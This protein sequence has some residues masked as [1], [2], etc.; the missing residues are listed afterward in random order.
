MTVCA[1]GQSASPDAEQLNIVR[2]FLAWAQRADAGGRA[3]A[4]S[5]LARAY[6]YSDLDAALRHEAEMGLTLLLDDPCALVRRALAEALAGA[7][8]APH[9]VILALACDQSEVSAAVLARSPVLT[10]AE[11]VDCAAIGDGRAQAALAR[12]PRLGIGV[13]MALAEVGQREAVIALA[14]NLDADLSPGVMRRIAA[15]FGADAETREALLARPW[16]PST[17]RCDLVALTANALA[18]FVAACDWLG[19]ER[20]RRVAREASEQ[21]AICIANFARPEE[22]RALVRHLRERGALTIALLLRGL[23]SGDRALF[24]QALTELA[25]VPAARAAGFVGEPQSAGF[26]ALYSKAGLPPHLLPVFRAALVAIEATR[27]PANGEICWEL[28]QQVIGACER[29]KSPELD[30]LMSLLRRFESEAARLLARAFA[31]DATAPEAPPVLMRL[32]AAEMESDEAPLLVAAPPADAETQGAA[33][34]AGPPSEALA[35]P[36]ELPSD[37]AD[38]PPVELP[39]DAADA[40]PVELPADAIVGLTEAA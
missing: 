28:I 8:E 39:A 1:V 18:D 37:A 23:L 31:A 20:A 12:R 26:S 40:P 24:E 16:L 3:E 29:L 9:H 27:T 5:A 10:D 22:R 38:A 11:L 6:L 14:R 7:H 15:R 32:E 2:R 35:P 17:L 36:V 33:S 25:D 13:A 34:P 21:G 19:P 4:A 30:R